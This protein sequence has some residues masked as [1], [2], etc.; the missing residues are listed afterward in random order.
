MIAAGAASTGNVRP[1]AL[2]S[3]ARLNMEVSMCDSCEAL[4]INGVYCHEHGCPKARADPK[5]CDECGRRFHPSHRFQ[6]YCEE[7]ENDNQ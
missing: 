4:T 6:R 2:P 7:C 3:R 5:E 1:L